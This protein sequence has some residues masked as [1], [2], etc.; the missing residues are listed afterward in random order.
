MWFRQESDTPD[1]HLI[2]GDPVPLGYSESVADL[3]LD[4]GGDPFNEAWLRSGP[5]G[6]AFRAKDRAIAR[7]WDLAFMEETERRQ[8]V[9]QAPFKDLRVAEVL[10][11]ESEKKASQGRVEESTEMAR[12]ASLIVDQSF[13]GEV[14]RAE[15]LG[16]RVRC[17][18]G[19]ARRMVGDWEGAERWF[20]ASLSF[21]RSPSSPE[22]AYLYQM[23]AALREDQGRFD[24]ALILLKQVVVCRS[25][26]KRLWQPEA[27]SL[28][29]T[30]FIYLKRN[31][32]WRAYQAFAQARMQLVRDDSS[33]VL[34]AQIDLGLSVCLAAS[35][36]EELAGELLARARSDRRS[37]RKEDEKITSEWLDCRIALHLGQV[38]SA[39]TRL[40]AICRWFL[41]YSSY[42]AVFLCSLDLLRA[43][44]KRKQ[45]WNR[46][47]AGLDD[48]ERLC[49]VEKATWAKEALKI[50]REA[51]LQDGAD[52]EIAID[53]AAAMVPLAIELSV[54]DF[55]LV[56]RRHAVLSENSKPGSRRKGK[57][58]GTGLRFDAALFEMAGKKKANF[59]PSDS[60]TGES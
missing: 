13:P 31:D 2:F 22:R 37:I 21:L 11:E 54:W 25:S 60:G 55:G 46:A 4:V 39:I 9:A 23:L 10:L 7:M 19:N 24:E 51:M 56:L 15:A 27:H 18:L 33:L 35:G 17:L 3:A 26:G 53:E 41:R 38:E 29:R 58:V 48:L 34:A 32:P 6:P 44:A 57:R 30:G 16:A 8:A 42:A 5:L 49:E 1:A 20:K 59:T 50:L 52:A 40:E 43:Y 12:L 36:L 28:A 14:E 47:L 45:G